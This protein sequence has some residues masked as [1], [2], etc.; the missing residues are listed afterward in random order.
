MKKA[1]RILLC[2]VLGLSLW[3]CTKETV[4]TKPVFT[5]IYIG[6]DDPEWSLINSV[7]AESLL[8][9]LAYSK[10]EKADKDN[11][12]PFDFMAIEENETTN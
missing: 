4:L 11:R 3:A 1:V 12:V 7:E 9:I 8:A 5:A 10:W 2:M 6:S